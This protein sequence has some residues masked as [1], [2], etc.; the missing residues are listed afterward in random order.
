MSL[1][2]EI[3]QQ[4]QNERFQ[5]MVNWFVF[6]MVFP[7]INIL[8]NSITF[9]FFLYFVIQL[10]IYWRNNFFLKGTFFALIG[11]FVLAAVFAPYSE[12][13]RYRGFTHTFQLTIQYI[14]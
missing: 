5:K 14:Y 4:Y 1:A 6:F 3:E 11:V 8:D 7:C 9:Y 13:T 2:L 12:M 10:G